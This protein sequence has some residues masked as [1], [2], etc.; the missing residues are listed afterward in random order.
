MHPRIKTF[1]F[2]LAL[3]VAAPVFAAEPIVP[4]S[5]GSAP[6]QPINPNEP[7]KPIFKNQV[8]RVTA[9]TA[10]V[11]KPPRVTTPTKPVPKAPAFKPR[12][13]Y[14]PQPPS[15]VRPGAPV[16]APPGSVIVPPAAVVRQPG[17]SDRARAADVAR[18]NRVQADCF[19]RCN[20]ATFGQARNL[21][22]NQCNARFV[23]CTNRANV[24]R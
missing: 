4:L 14:V 6:R 21:C 3:A 15:V 20:H 18:C 22:Y 12:R 16:V 5:S 11:P 24:R 8:P 1:L 9:P 2:C 23:T 10:P 19:Q 17:R 7:G 13:K